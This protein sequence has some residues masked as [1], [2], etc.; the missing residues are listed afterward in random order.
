MAKNK[1]KY[2]EPVY[3]DREEQDSALMSAIDDILSAEEQ[4][5][6]ILDEAEEQAK[7]IRA[8]AAA[9]EHALCEEHAKRLNVKRDE[10]V[11]AAIERAAAEGKVR[12]EKANTDG[13]KLVAEKK[14]Q[15]AKR[16]D[17]LYA[18]IGGK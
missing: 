4:A 1:V 14:S 17:I 13:E 11:R 15:I 12:A 2:I 10:L 6:R 16:I 8:D 18:D 9:K 3:A 7:T 5:K